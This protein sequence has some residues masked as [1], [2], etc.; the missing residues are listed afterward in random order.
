MLARADHAVTVVERD[1]LV[2]AADVEAAAA[3]A[4]LNGA[5]DRAATRPA[6]DLPRSRAERP[7]R[8]PRTDGCRGGRGATAHPA[9]VVRRRPLDEA[10]RRAAAA[11]DDAPCNPRRGAV[12]RGGGRTGGA[13]PARRSGHGVAAWSKTAPT[14]RS[15]GLCRPP[16]ATAPSKNPPRRRS[17]AKPSSPWYR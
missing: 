7:G 4:F 3:G 9:A 6:P 15:A 5:P 13:R 11:A 12:P 2:P 17:P 10:E 8:V 14:G 1:H 16:A